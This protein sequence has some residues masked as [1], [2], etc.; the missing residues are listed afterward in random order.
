MLTINQL[1]TLTDLIFV[2]RIACDLIL[3]MIASKWL[4]L[5]VGMPVFQPLYEKKS[6]M[7]KF[8]VLQF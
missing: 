3:V 6:K 5:N 1:Y 4:V 7:S 8:E 2:I